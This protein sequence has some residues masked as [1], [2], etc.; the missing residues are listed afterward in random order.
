MPTPVIFISYSH[1][2]NEH[3]ERVLGLSERLRKDGFE[4]VLD[5]YVN[6]APVGGWPRWM[7]DRLD[8]A[9]FVLVLCTETYYRR[10]RGHELPDRGKGVDWEGALITQEIYD[11][12]SRTL[13][14]IPVLFEPAQTNF[15]PEP[16]RGLVTYTL[17]SDFGYNA[18]TDFLDGTGGIVPGPI[19][20]RE[21]KPPARGKPLTFDAAAKQTAASTES[22][23]AESSQSHHERRSL[24]FVVHVGKSSGSKYPVA[25]FEGDSVTAQETMVF[26]YD[27][28]VLENHLL[29]LTNAVLGSASQRR[30]AESN[31]A[32]DVRE[33]GS[34]LF[35]ALITGG[36]RDRYDAA[37]SDASQ[38]R[39][40]C[41]ILLHIEEAMELAGL[42][43]EFI[44]DT[45]E[46]Q[47]PCL[48]RNTPVVRH[49]N[50]SRTRQPFT[51]TSPLRILAMF[52]N[53]EM[54]SP[55]DGEREKGRLLKVVEA[56]GTKV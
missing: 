52:A 23:I 13:K 30:D 21:P 2:S 54:D 34:Q 37:R 44:F 9:T 5:R 51:R 33:F 48:S 43:W 49:L 12:R 24:D 18:L 16:I 3:R 26:P 6:G 4:T 27:G 36:I 53:P 47:F 55:I 39:I 8:Q 46:D 31:G 11:D 19:G 50:V 32:K 25:V 40:E 42:P 20:K 10:F 22:G 15:V 17:N 38:Q 29:K 7:L 28:I 35:N 41:R 45:R 14:F 56:L 1:D